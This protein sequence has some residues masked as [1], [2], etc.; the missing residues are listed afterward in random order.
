[1]NMQ[2]REPDADNCFISEKRIRFHHC[3]PAGIVFYPQYF[4][5][6]NELVEDWYTYGLGVS[7]AEQIAKDRV[8]I[9]L[10]KAS[11][12]FLAPSRIGDGLRMSLRV[13]HIGRSSLVLAIEGA[14]GECVRIRA[15]LT[16]VNASLETLRP[17]P[18][19]D[20]L[21]RRMEAYLV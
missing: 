2:T 8:S 16:A 9:P 17:V 3:D 21:R 5:L 13:R 20:E 18:I 14:S 6:C 4:V 11:C 12:E 15:E 7:F 10:A 1:M 19:A